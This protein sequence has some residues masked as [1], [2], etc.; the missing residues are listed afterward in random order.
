MFRFTEHPQA[1]SYNKVKVHSAS[2][3]AMGSHSVRTRC[4]YLYFAAR[5]GL[6]IVQ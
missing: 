4:M 2:A 1:N 3:H 5:I 6:R